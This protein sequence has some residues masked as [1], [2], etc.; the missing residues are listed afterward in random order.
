MLS[1][2]NRAS[3]G[4]SQHR[5]LFIPNNI[6]NDD[7]AVEI[8]PVSSID[9]LELFGRIIYEEV[10]QHTHDV[11]LGHGV[12]EANETFQQFKAEIDGS[13]V[14]DGFI[15]P[16]KPVDI[17]RDITGELSDGSNLVTVSPLMTGEKRGIELR[18]KV[19][20]EGIK[21]ATEPQQ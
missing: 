14:T 6:N 5:D 13:E 9:S 21:N 4:Q 19:E 7:I 8:N 18:A 2:D 15:S 11:A 16:P 12:A 1:P 3:A 20:L 17:T 10:G